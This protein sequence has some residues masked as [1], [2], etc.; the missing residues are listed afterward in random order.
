MLCSSVVLRLLS[1]IVAEEERVPGVIDTQKQRIMG[2]DLD[3]LAALAAVDSMEVFFVQADRPN[4]SGGYF[5]IR[6][7]R[8]QELA[9]QQTRVASVSELTSRPRE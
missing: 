3:H 7:D 5:V 8:A 1:R 4:R 6:Y 2:H 9:A